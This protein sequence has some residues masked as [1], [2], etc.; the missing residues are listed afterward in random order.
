MKFAIVGGIKKEAEPKES[1]NCICCGTAVRAYC[2]PER[3]NHWKH[4]SLEQC[5]SWYEGET[6]WHRRW[7]NFFDESYQECVRFASSG[8]KHIADIYIPTRDVVIE[9]QHSPI[10]HAEIKSREE[11]Y[12]RMVWVVDVFP[13]VNNITLHDNLDDFIDLVELPWAINQDKKF[14]ELKRAGKIDEAENL[15]RD[16]SEW[17]Y[18]Q[19]FEK[20]YSEGGFKSD[21]FLM[22]WKYQHKRWNITS[23]PV[24]FDLNDGSLYMVVESIKVWNGFIVRQIS[25]ELFVS[26]YSKA[27]Q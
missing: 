15:R 2:G 22:V 14:R 26:H 10:T 5:D 7:K 20:R 23:K 4:L 11:F 18:L 21:Y 9:F 3:I 16:F 1:G 25:R 12:E 6:D 19:N 24:F 13:F 8:E 17:D 27:A